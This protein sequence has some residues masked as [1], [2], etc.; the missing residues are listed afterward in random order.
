MVL[1]IQTG[2]WLTEPVRTFELQGRLGWTLFHLDKAGSEGELLSNLVFEGCRSCGDL[3][4]VGG[5]NSVFER[6]A[7]DDFCQVIKAA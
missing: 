6:D 3:A 1:L 2:L 5:F 7:C 4:V